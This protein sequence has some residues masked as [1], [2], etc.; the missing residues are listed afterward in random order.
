MYIITVCKTLQIMLRSSSK[1]TWPHGPMPWSDT[2]CPGMRKTPANGSTTEDIHINV[3]VGTVLSNAFFH[4]VL[5]LV[6]NVSML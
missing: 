4:S 2:P 5:G 1:T 3:R 6:Q